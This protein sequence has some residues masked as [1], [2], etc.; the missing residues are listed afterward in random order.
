[1]YKKHIKISKL[2]KDT[3]KTKTLNIVSK[4]S[5]DKIENNKDF[6]LEKTRIKINSWHHR[7]I[8]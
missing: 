7:D 5:M 4:N 1:M 3:I 2:K 8:L 6:D